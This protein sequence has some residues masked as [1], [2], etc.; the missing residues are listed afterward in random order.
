MP[1]PEQLTNTREKH[2]TDFI[3]FYKGDNTSH[4]NTQ[5]CL[6]VLLQFPSIVIVS[7][8]KMTIHPFSCLDK[9][10]KISVHSQPI[11]SLISFI[12][13]FPHFIYFENTSKSDRKFLI[14]LLLRLLPHLSVNPSTIFLLM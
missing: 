3:S 4:F 13:H 8:S 1:A 9:S 14:F 5:H 7:L 2:T 6:T 11:I 10:P 12:F